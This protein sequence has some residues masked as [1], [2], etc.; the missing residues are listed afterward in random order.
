MGGD[1]SGSVAG[2]LRFGGCLVLYV[3]GG[4]GGTVGVLGGEVEG[5]GW[6]EGGGLD[7]VW[8]WGGLGSGGEGEWLEG[9][10]EI[11]VVLI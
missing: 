11:G 3:C 8:V 10:G 1:D 5:E 4:V 7:G 2:G 6:G 9:K